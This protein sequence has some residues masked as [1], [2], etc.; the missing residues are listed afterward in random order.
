MARDLMDR[1][2][3]SLGGDVSGLDQCTPTVKFHHG[4]GGVRLP[5]VQRPEPQADGL[6][7]ALSKF[8]RTQ[9]E[10]TLDTC[11]GVICGQP[12]RDDLARPNQARV[13]LQIDR[14]PIQAGFIAPDKRP[15]TE[16]PD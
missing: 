3:E 9:T 15:R 5:E 10:L 4:P 12:G 13:T 1:S 14:H 2:V 11:D 6:G 7:F 8:V 16:Q